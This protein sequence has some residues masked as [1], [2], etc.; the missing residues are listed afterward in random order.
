MAATPGRL[1]GA[2]CGGAGVIP[3]MAQRFQ[4]MN[5]LLG[6]SWQQEPDAPA[7][8]QENL[9]GRWGVG[10]HASPSHAMPY[11]AQLCRGEVGNLARRP[12][13]MVACPRSTMTNSRPAAGGGPPSAQSW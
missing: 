11:P 2:A 13:I 10:S 8:P 9:G 7:A 6:E 3:G 1:G 4:A 5:Q 12:G